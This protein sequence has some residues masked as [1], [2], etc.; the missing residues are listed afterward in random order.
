[1]R[2][3]MRPKIS[4]ESYRRKF[5][6]GRGELI[7]DGKVDYSFRSDN[8]ARFAGRT[9]RP[10]AAVPANRIPYLH[11]RSWKGPLL[12]R[13]QLRSRAYFSSLRIDS[14]YGRLAIMM[15]R[16]PVKVDLEAITIDRI[17]ANGRYEVLFDWAC[18]CGAITIGEHVE[19]AHLISLVHIQ[20]KNCGCACFATMPD[21]VTENK[22]ALPRRGSAKPKVQTRKTLSVGELCGNG[23]SE[24]EMQLWERCAANG[25]HGTSAVESQTALMIM[26]IQHWPALTDICMAAL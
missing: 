17:N 6:A 11:G 13:H 26:S 18:R 23:S 9:W 12:P 10:L 8:I 25:S 5:L 24:P 19:T 2:P 7:Y 22:R 20:C 21:G 16:P 15:I 14:Q 3:K 4:T 1:M